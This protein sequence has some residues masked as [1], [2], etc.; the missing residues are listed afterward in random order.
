MDRMRSLRQIVTL[1][2][3]GNFRKA[4]ERLGV[5]HSA[6]SQAIA[7]L[8]DSYGVPLFVRNKQETV[9]TAFGRRMVEAARQALVEIERAE[10]D[11]AM[12]RNWETGILTIGSDPNLAESLLAPVLV[13]M[14][15]RHPNVRIKVLSRNWQAMEHSLIDKSI[16][17]YVGLAPD[18]RTDALVYDSIPLAPPVCVCRAGHPLVGKGPLRIADIRPFP[19]LA[20]DAPTWYLE[21]VRQT[22]PDELTT[23]DAVRST[24]LMTQDLGLMRKMI[25]ETDALGVLPPQLV[26]GALKRGEMAKLKF[27]RE[28]FRGRLPGVIARLDGYPLP[29]IAQA[30]VSRIHR[31]VQ[32]ASNESRRYGF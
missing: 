1:A 11:V 32:R 2:D 20:G 9:P 23:L 7:K 6:L 19:F 17:I 3:A 22:Y 31:A 27:V 25:A 4:A 13:S 15:R 26:L 29:P 24:F 8:E 12:M 16:D 28:P 14:M 5:T 30:L 18:R 10:R 21:T